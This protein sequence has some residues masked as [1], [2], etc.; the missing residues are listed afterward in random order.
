MGARRNDERE[1]R[2]GYRG[3]RVSSWRVMMATKRSAHS[4]P[5]KRQLKRHKGA[6]VF[7]GSAE[8]VLATDVEEMAIHLAKRSTAPT[9][10]ER[11]GEYVVD[12]K[13]L[14]STGDGIGTA[15]DGESIVVVPFTV[16]GDKVATRVY[17]TTET[18]SLGDF[19]R[20]E[21]KGESRFDEG[22]LC[23]YFER[24]GGCQL[25]MLRYADQLKHKQNVVSQAFKHYSGLAAEDVPAVEETMPSPLQWAYRTKLTPHFDSLKGGDRAV[26]IGFL[27]KGRRRVL[28]I[29]ECPIATPV[30][31]ENLPRVRAVVHENIANYKRGASLLLRQSDNLREPNEGKVVCVTDN[32]AIVQ[33]TVGDYKFQFKAGSF[34]QNNNS[35]L[36]YVLDYILTLSKECKDCDYLVDTY[37]G[38]GFFSVGLASH[39]KQVTGIEISSESVVAARNNSTLNNCSNTSY[40]EGS[41]EKIF[42]TVEYEANKTLVIID[43][44]RKGSD[45]AFLSQLV[46]FRPKG[47]IYVSCNVHT[48]ARD[49]GFIVR[50][51][52]TLERLRGFD[53]FPQT[54]HVESVALLTLR[55]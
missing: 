5:R 4:M 27:Q 25:Q 10:I 32:N 52:Y 17:H 43:P 12:I 37:C 42:D 1:D 3:M 21:G 34:F 2:D 53:F 46:K 7:S 6:T 8:Q 18:H 36:P 45:E 23:K 30:I 19:I 49:I 55:S 40:V 41:A 54:H 44:P 47:I 26:D 38:A 13:L 31:Q 20:I 9:F 35:I 48:Q 39:F 16:P 22:K 15:E 11:Y 33:E 29:E 50:N 24:C 28:D 14:S 51:G